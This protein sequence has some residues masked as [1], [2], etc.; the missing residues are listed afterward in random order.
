MHVV[1]AGG[2]G[3]VGQA[4][5]ETL[6]SH[7]ENHVTVLSRNPEKIEQSDRLK[8]VE[9]L[10]EGSRPEEK[11]NDVDAVVNL[12]GESINGLRWTTQKKKRI[13]RSRLKATDQILE[14]LG[15]LEPKPKV[16]VNAS[17]VGY[18]GMS[19]TGCYTEKHQSTADDF[20]AKT[21]QKWEE[22][23]AEANRLGVRTV[24]ARFGLVLGTKGALPLM[25]LPYRFRIGG[26][27]GSGR[28]WVSWIHVKDA[29]RIIQFAIHTP[30]VEGP[31]NVT[32]PHP[33]TMKTFGEILGASLRKPHWLPVPE[34]IIK[35]ALGEMSSMLV[36]G[37]QVIPEKAI[38]L[39]YDFQFPKLN[40]ALS[41]TLQNDEKYRFFKKK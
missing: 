20:L 13:V 8:A 16:L 15:K 38:Q 27:L 24:F 34:G 35:L 30:E 2:S 41:D 40:E 39:Q 23:A 4:L 32:A 22:R 10:N 5:Q 25:A 33:V 21:V 37:Q 12:A 36:Q 29:A 17:A 26:T 11:L 28:Q 1:I 9:W 3:F 14:L 6:L 18:Y 7:R 19:E 31:F